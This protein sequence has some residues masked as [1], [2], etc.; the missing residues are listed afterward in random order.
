MEGEVQLKVQAK[1]KE[2]GDTHGKE[3]VEEQRIKEQ[4]TARAMQYD[5][6]QLVRV[7][8]MRK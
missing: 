2:I 1:N 6:Q 5:V 3:Q 4:T 7:H 8:C